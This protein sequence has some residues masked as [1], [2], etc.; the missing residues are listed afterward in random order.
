MTELGAES[1]IL[2]SSLLCSFYYMWP[3]IPK[4]DSKALEPGLAESDDPYV[5]LRLLLMNNQ[6]WGG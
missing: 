3:R 2:Y 1:W 4:I 5:V 6:Q